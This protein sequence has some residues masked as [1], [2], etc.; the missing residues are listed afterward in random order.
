MGTPDGL[1]VQT[2][3]ANSSWVDIFVQTATGVYA[4]I[5]KS[6][7]S[8]TDFGN[9]TFTQIASSTNDTN[10]YGLAL[11][12]AQTQFLT[13]DVNRDGIVN[14]QDLAIVSSEWQQTGAGLVGDVNHDDIVNAQDLAIVSSE[15]QQTSG[16]SGNSVATVPEPNSAL[17]ALLA[18]VVGVG[19][20]RRAQSRDNDAPR[21]ATD[22]R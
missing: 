19:T 21:Q 13:G 20:I 22:A 17:L 12:P 18:I 9:L 5:D 6:G 16:G 4:A 3:P 11:I 7:A 15:W 10:F 8:N 1:S 14:S 2:D